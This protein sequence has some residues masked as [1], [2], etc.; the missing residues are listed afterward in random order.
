M[1]L[2]IALSSVRRS[3]KS[4]LVSAF[5]TYTLKKN[6]RISSLSF[7]RSSSTTSKAKVL[8]STTEE[9]QEA[10]PKTKEGEYDIINKSKGISKNY[11]PQAFEDDIYKWWEDSNCFAPEKKKAAPNSKPYVLPMPPPNVTGK[12]HMGHAIFVS[13]QDILARFH[14]MRQKEVLWLPGTD[15]AGIATQLQVEKQLN[16]EGKTR[17]D[18]GREAFLEKT[19]EYKEQ[20]GGFITKQLRSLGASADWKREKFTLEP[21]LNVAVNE[22]FVRLYEKGLIYKG[23]YMVNWA[24]LLQTAVSDLEVEYTEENGKLYYFKYFLKSDSDVISDEHEYLPVA[25]TRPET[26]LGDTAVCVHPDDERY[27]K[28]IGKE[29]VVP[30]SNHTIPVI[31]DTYVDMEFGTGALKITPG[32][33]IN[34]YTLGKKYNL[35]TINIMNKDGT[36]NANVHNKKYINLDRFDCRTQLWDDMTKEGYVIKVNEDYTQRVPRSQRGGEVI[37]PMVS[38]QWFV[39]TKEMADKSLKAVENGDLTII[40]KRFEKTWFNW[41]DDI[42]DWCISRQ[43]WWGH[44][45]PVW[46]IIGDT[47]SDVIS[48]EEKFIVA[49]NGEEAK[50]KAIEM[51]YDLDKVTLKQDDD[52]LDT[53][54]SSGLWP[55]ATMGWPNTDSSDYNKFYPGTCLETGYDIIFFWVARMVMLGYA[56]TDKCAFEVVYLHGLVRAAD[57]SKMS[58]T[59]GNVVDPID[60]VQ[61]YGADSL[62]YSLVTGVT[63]GQDIPLNMDKIQANRNF[64]NKLWNICK[65][66]T[67]NALKDLSTEEF[68]SLAVTNPITQ[69]EYNTLPLPERYIL[70]KCHALVSSVTNDIENYNL[71]VAGNKVYEFLWDEFADWYIEIAKTRLYTGAGGTLDPVELQNTRK[72]LVYILDTSLKLLHPYMPFVTEQL[73]HHL[74]RKEI[75]DGQETNALMLADWPQLNDDEPLYYSNADIDTF[76]ILKIVTRSIRNARSEYD[77]Q[78]G[79]RISATIVVTDDNILNELQNEIKSL[80][81]LTKLDPEKVIITSTDMQEEDDDVDGK[82]KDN[83]QLVISE[84]IKAYL[85]LS[86][87]VDVEKERARLE[88]QLT[89]LQKDIDKLSSRLESKGFVDKA[90]EVVVNKVREELEELNGKKNKIV[91]GLESL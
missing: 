10:T 40:P 47:N 31:A 63:P 29:V 53:W 21:D 71:G 20:Q 1:I 83:V 74:P 57:G 67:E 75:T 58:K 8:F 17:Y 19:W 11:N 15:H 22:A 3:N 60:T 81:V 48:E 72:I 4:I 65:F 77:V 52:V 24:P 82:K 42:H 2:S 28:Y 44:R 6:N 36:M 84:T 33:D 49:R 16:A 45:I 34:D 55:F 41:L 38:S 86:E 78:P 51:G 62:R 39:R 12:L 50:E 18:I 88:R 56:L 68:N 91:D 66:V 13:I 90:P 89:K 70:S 54:F 35:P 5:T 37:E 43:L 80:I 73:W 61:E 27:K 69:D 32:H 59:K 30:L 9:Q 7:F 26:I 46:Y 23:E 76:Q 64:A 87:L 85:P 79:K 14:R 25:T